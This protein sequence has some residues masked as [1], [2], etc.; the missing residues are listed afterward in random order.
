MSRPGRHVVLV[1]RSEPGWLRS[2]EEALRAR[3]ID[4]VEAYS[5]WSAEL[6]LERMAGDAVVIAAD[7]LCDFVSVDRPG[8]LLGLSPKLPVVVFHAE[9]LDEQHRSAATAHNAL[10]VEGDD[11]AEITRCVDSVLPVS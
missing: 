6:A 7:V 4:T 8:P 10:L 9:G 11:I 5:C 1:T 3:G 2:C